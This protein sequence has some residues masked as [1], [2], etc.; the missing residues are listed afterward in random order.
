MVRPCSPLCPFGPLPQS[1]PPAP[2]FIKDCSGEERS[3]YRVWRLFR[4]IWN[5]ELPAG[6]LRSFSVVYSQA[7][8]KVCDQVS[9]LTGKPNHRAA[10]HA[11][12][13][14]FLAQVA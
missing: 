4:L 13:G 6:L 2:L 3:R 12:D 5:R 10:K 7:A 11:S 14:G 8:A 1:S 9:R